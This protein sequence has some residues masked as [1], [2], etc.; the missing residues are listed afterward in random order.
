[1]TECL[2][3]LKMRPAGLN[4]FAEHL[5]YMESLPDEIAKLSE[6]ADIVEKMYVLLDDGKAEGKVRIP[7]QDA[8]L[9]DELREQFPNLSSTR[10]QAE[11]Y[12]EAKIG[13][14][15][16]QLETYI[17]Q[18]QDMTMQTLLE[19]HGG[20][21]CDDMLLL[22]LM[23]DSILMLMPMP[24]LYWPNS[25]VWMSFLSKHKKRSIFTHA[26]NNYLG[27]QNKIVIFLLT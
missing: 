15:A 2:Q 14:M 5:I 6:E 20:I 9:R 7:T 11:A 25:K 10:E 27:L 24:R 16:T 8:V 1:M 17:K 3:A 18:V 22:V 23:V 21:V 26:T 13:P 12:K 4:E 19:L